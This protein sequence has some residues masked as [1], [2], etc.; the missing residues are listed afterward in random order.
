LIY[1]Y[2]FVK[3]FQGEPSSCEVAKG[4][5]P[6]QGKSAWQVLKV[7][8]LFP[9]LEGI[10]PPKEAWNRVR[11]RLVPLEAEGTVPRRDFLEQPQPELINTGEL[12]F[13]K[14]KEYIEREGVECKG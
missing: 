4:R 3:S 12:A 9:V 5:N 11:V 1:N 6:E 10:P 8:F 14:M 7:A 2:L 13:Q